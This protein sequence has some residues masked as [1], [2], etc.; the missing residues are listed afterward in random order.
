MDEAE[1]EKIGLEPAKSTIKDLGGWL[2]ND[3]PW[4][5]LIPD[6]LDKGS[7]ANDFILSLDLKVDP[8]KPTQRV[9]TIDQPSFGISRE[10]FAKS[11]ENVDAY[12]EY[13]KDTAMLFGI[14]Q[15]NGGKSNQFELKTRIG[16]QKII[17]GDLSR[18]EEKIAK[19]KVFYQ[20]I[21]LDSTIS[22]YK[23]INLKFYNQI[24]CE[25]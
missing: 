23:T 6:L 3:K 2:G 7:P 10:F 1:I 19:L 22:D 4:D 13:V 15:I 24:V 16:D 20:K 18:T 21:M 5:E 17:F 8:R 25:K 9:L 14:D 12:Q 11:D